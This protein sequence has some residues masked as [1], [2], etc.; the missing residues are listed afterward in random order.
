MP[1]IL[2]SL[3]THLQGHSERREQ[4]RLLWAHPV[5]VCFL[6]EDGHTGDAFTC[7]AKDISPTGMGLYLSRV[8]AGGAL[9]VTLTTPNHP[10]PVTL[11]A[12]CV[13]V[14]RCGDGWFEAGV[15]FQ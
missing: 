15:L 14:Q 5:E 12:T 1:Q 6:G 7:H 4:E 11:L 8:T 13:R 3:R 10:E 9:T 2:A